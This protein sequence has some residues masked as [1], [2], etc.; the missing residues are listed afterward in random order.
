[1]IVLVGDRKTIE[2]PVRALNLGPITDM[3]VDDVLGKAPVPRR[4][5]PQTCWKSGAVPLGSFSKLRHLR[6][7]GTAC[8]A[9][10]PG[11]RWFEG[12]TVS[13]AE[14][15]L[16]RA[17]RPEWAPRTALVFQSESRPHTGARNAG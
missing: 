8:S 14:Q 7:C 13:Y 10:M 6:G 5:P 11:A 2:R 3:T 9:S 4:S 17:L 15:S 1:M 16:W 12:A